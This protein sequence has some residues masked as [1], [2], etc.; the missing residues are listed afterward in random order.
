MDIVSA[1]VDAILSGEQIRTKGRE[2]AQELS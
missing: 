2:K 1:N